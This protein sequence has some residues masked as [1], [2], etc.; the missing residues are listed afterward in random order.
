[1]T[2]M[3]KLNLASYIK[4]EIIKD[5]GKITDIIIKSVDL[6]NI[7][8]LLYEKVDPKNNLKDPIIHQQYN[9]LGQDQKLMLA[10][11]MLITRYCIHRVLTI[12]KI[13]Q[14]DVWD[15]HVG[16]DYYGEEINSIV[17]KPMIANKISSIL[18]CL[19][20]RNISEKIETVLK[21]DYGRLIPSIVKKTW[22]V[23]QVSIKD[24][25][26][27]NQEHYQQCINELTEQ[28]E[29]KSEYHRTLLEYPYPRAITILNPDD[30]YKVIDGYH[31]LVGIPK[32]TNP[33][34]IYCLRD[35]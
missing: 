1:M 35:E 8:E 34:I 15:Y 13:Y 27:S 23:K 16:A 12:F 17:I 19:R 24:L 10:T 26:Y 28:N 2:N 9:I 3:D 7:V 6:P 18:E 30:K 29:L 14:R 32:D 20:V 11:Q 25:Y 4:Y 22:Y 33:L 31:R 5:K 21:L